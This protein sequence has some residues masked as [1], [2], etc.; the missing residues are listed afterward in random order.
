M[1]DFVKVCP[2]CKHPNPEYLNVCEQCQQFIAME[3]PSAKTSSV[4]KSSVE[5]SSV[6]NASLEASFEPPSRVKNSTQSNKKTAPAITTETTETNSIAATKLSKV[7]KNQSLVYLEIA[8]TGQ[9]LSIKSGEVMGQEHPTGIAEVKVP[10]SI[11]GAEYIHR[12]HCRFDYHKGH[13]FILPIEQSQYQQDF[14]NPTMLNRK[15]LSADSQH[16][17]ADGDVIHLSAVKFSVRLLA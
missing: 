17:L 6:E 3:V 7:A 12:Q 13:W 11:E 14:T 9:L 1:T 5:K 2:K 10:S 8:A 16:Q 4:E 15:M